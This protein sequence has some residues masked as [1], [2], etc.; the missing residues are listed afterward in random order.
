MLD[1]DAFVQK[2][3]K[4]FKV[5]VD[6]TK[7]FA[8]MLLADTTFSW[9][10]I[11]ND[12]FPLDDYKQLPLFPEL[13]KT[14]FFKKHL[15]IWREFDEDVSDDDIA[16]KTLQIFVA[17]AFVKNALSGHRFYNEQQF[18][19]MLNSTYTGL[20]QQK[21]SPQGIHIN[22]VYRNSLEAVKRYG[23]HSNKK[24]H[25]EEDPKPRCCVIS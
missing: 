2:H 20:A 1:I 12:A 18:I 22:F 7:H 21:H 16:A 3:Q 17:K 10:D 11:E 15:I 24:I 25:P 19:A 8:D 23:M 14:L 5:I 4:N 9:T 13:K 6:S